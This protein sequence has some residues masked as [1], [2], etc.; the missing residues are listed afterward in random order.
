ML[1][2][3]YHWPHIFIN[4]ALNNRSKLSSINIESYPS[5]ECWVIMKQ[6]QMSAQKMNMSQ[7]RL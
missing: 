3:D 5:F 2:K 7:K 4:C 1:A 6:Y